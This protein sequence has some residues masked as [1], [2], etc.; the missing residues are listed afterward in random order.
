[1]KESIEKIVQKAIDEKRII[2]KNTGG[3]YVK[4]ES[5]RTIDDYL[6][7]IVQTQSEII[8]LLDGI[9]KLMIEE[10]RWRIHTEGGFKDD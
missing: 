7:I 3:D 10:K 8:K 4:V 5:I 9:M 2:I 6:A 1:M